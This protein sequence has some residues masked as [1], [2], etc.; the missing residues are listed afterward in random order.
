MLIQT[1]IIEISGIYHLTPGKKITLK[2]LE[3][4]AYEKGVMT[5]T[6]YF[7]KNR[8]STGRVFYSG[9]YTKAT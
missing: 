6:F 7:Y 5:V 1:L 4:S 3:F 8:I 2:E 9:F